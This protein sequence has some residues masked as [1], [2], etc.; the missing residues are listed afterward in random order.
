[1]FNPISERT[2]TG[3]LELAC[4][5]RRNGPSP[6]SEA[7]ESPV[8]PPPAPGRVQCAC[9]I[10]RPRLES[11]PLPLPRKKSGASRL[12]LPAAPFIFLRRVPNPFIFLE[13]QAPPNPF[14]SS[15]LQARLN[16]RRRPVLPAETLGRDPG[17]TVA[18]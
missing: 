6:P 10:R 4:W 3:L 15:S 18:P 13:N 16:P 8:L 14:G 1:M 17:M 7:W 9:E 2:H 11:R 5:A 12:Q